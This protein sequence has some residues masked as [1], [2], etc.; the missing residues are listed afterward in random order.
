MKELASSA[1]EMYGIRISQSQLAS[2]EYYEQQLIA[3][4]ARYN[5]TAIKDPDKIRVRHFLDSL[6]CLCV[7]RK[8][9]MEKVIDIGTGAGFPGLPIKIVQPGIEL[10]LVDSVGKKTEFCRHIV[11]ELKLEGVKV[12][13][14]RAE[15][16]GKEGRH[17]QRYDWALARAVAVL[18][19]LLEYT[20]PL[21]RVGGSVLAMKGES[22]HSEVQNGENAMKVL[23]GH[24]REV[25]QV[26]LPGVAEDHHLIVV[27]KVAATPDGYPRRIGI[28]AKRPL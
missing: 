20:L 27:D 11:R 13:Q 25:L 5:L 14:S 15:E 19:T 16:I 10:T 12:I 3:W 21:V 1:Y 7:M 8:S 9:S 18:P 23:G 28:P 2:L 4:N 24:L 22:A 6:S 17:R 26:Q